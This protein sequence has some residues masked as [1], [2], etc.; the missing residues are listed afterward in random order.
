M[1]IKS[2]VL[3]T[4]L[5]LAS[6]SIVAQTLNLSALDRTHSDLKRDKTAK[7][8]QII[9]FSGIS[10]GM[11]VADIFA[12]GGY[13]SELLSQAV[14]STGKVYLH[15]NQTYVKVVGEELSTRIKDNRLINVV[16]Y[17]REAEQLDFEQGSL[18][19][20]FFVLGYHDMY[21]KSDSWNI[22]GQLLLNQL[23]KALKPGGVL[24]VVDHSAPQ[25]TKTKHSQKL[26]RIGEDYV[27]GELTKNGF[28]FI[29][30]SQMLR[31][32][33]DTR[34]I[35]P[36]RPEIRRKTDRFVLLFKKL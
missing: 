20:V 33:Y 35:S 36:F 34:L 32:K 8:A 24:L 9:E 29:K 10:K 3:A 28:K 15:N 25:G 13:Y 6:L 4:C 5:G 22:D 27:K 7:P 31:N 30:D 14:G 21:H 17:R 11:T 19:A 16:D 12:G 1:M 18:D 2:L 26:H 23:K